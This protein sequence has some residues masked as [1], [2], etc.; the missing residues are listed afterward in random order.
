[1]LVRAVEQ[2]HKQIARLRIAPDPTVDPEREKMDLLKQT[3]RKSTKKS[4]DRY[5]SLG[6][7]HKKPKRSKD[8]DLIWSDDDDER[9]D[10]YGDGSDEEDYERM[11]RSSPRKAKRKPGEEKGEEDYR[12]DGFVVPDESD[13]DADDG[14]R[15]RKR[16]REGSDAEDDLERMEASLEKQAA[17]DK[18]VRVHEPKKSK[19]A[20]R[21]DDDT[22]G[23]AGAMDVE[24]EE[25]EDEEFK[26]RRVTSKRAIAFEDEDEE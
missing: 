16:G 9:G 8:H 23:G 12:A 14:G 1:M 5:D 19:K 2:R 24:S 11:D 22:D 21:S 17:A 10:M 26:V 18:K 25:E 7:A 3:A 4:T 6:G 13:E 20:A 15:R